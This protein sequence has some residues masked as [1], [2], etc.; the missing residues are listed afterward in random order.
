MKRP[1]SV[2]IG[3]ARRISRDRSAPLVIIF[4]LD[5]PRGDRFT[6]TTYGAT[7]GLCRLAAALGN[8]IGDLILDGTIAPPQVEPRDLPEEPTASERAR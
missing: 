6:V 3:D 5:D 2:P 7:K 1:G 8:Q 4:A